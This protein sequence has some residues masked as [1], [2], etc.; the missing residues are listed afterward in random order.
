[1]KI[2]HQ[3]KREGKIKVRIDNLDDLWHLKNIVN[4]EDVISAITYRREETQRDKIRSERGEKKRMRLDIEV[5]KVE[6][7][8][9]TDRL[10]ILGV[11]IEGPQDHGSYHT[12]NLTEGDELTIIKEWDDHEL[13]RLKEAVERSEEPLITFVALEEDEVTIAIMRQYGVKEMATLSPNRGGKMYDS[14]KMTREEFFEEIVKKLETIIDPGEPLVIL[15][16]G[17]TKEDFFEYCKRNHEELVKNSEVVPAGEGGMTGVNE[18]IKKGKERDTLDGQRMSYETEMVEELLREIK[19][20]G[21]YTYGMENVEEA[22][23]IG[24]VDTLL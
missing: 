20:D 17:F 12:L 24:A 9:F 19:S 7:H 14:E 6:F 3:D 22:V 2:L 11:I 8:E 5:E 1:M 15:G 18:V 13:D 23:R 4:P 21:A 16:P 10:R